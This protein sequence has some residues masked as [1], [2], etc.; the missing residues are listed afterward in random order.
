MF[1]SV[2]TI[3]VETLDKTFSL[4][5]NCIHDRV[6]VIMVA[7]LCVQIMNMLITVTNNCTR[8]L[9]PQPDLWYSRPELLDPRPELLNPRP[10]LWDTRP[11]L[12]DLRVDLLDRLSDLWDP[13]PDH[14]DLKG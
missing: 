2:K 4:F 10:E 5:P 3:Q 12:L 8:S 6:I 9:D 1:E 7:R 13:R 14:L 11:D